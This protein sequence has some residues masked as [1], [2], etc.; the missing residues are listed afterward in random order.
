MEDGSVWMNPEIAARGRYP[1]ASIQSIRAIE[2]NKILNQKILFRDG[3]DLRIDPE[4]T[5]VLVDDGIATGATVIASIRMLKDAGCKRIVVAVPVCSDDAADRIRNEGAE[6]F[7]LVETDHLRSVGLW[8]QD[9]TQVEDEAVVRILKGFK[10]PMPKLNPGNRVVHTIADLLQPLESDSDLDPLLQ[11]IQAKHIAMLGEASHGTSEFYRIRD[12]IS[13]KLLKDS[14]FS[15]VAVEGDWPDLYRLNRYAK[16]GKGKS[17]KQV[18]QSFRRW[19]TWMWSNG[20]FESFVEFMRSEPKVSECGIYGLDVYSLFESMDSALEYVQSVNPFLAKAMRARYSCFEPYE[21][22]EYAYSRSLQRIPEGCSV[23]VLQNLEALLQMRMEKGQD[24][25]GRFS[26]EQNARIAVNAEN[27]YRALLGGDEHS[28]NVRDSHMLDTLDLLLDRYSRKKGTASKGIVW[29]HNTHVGDY[30]A[31]DMEREGYVNLGGLARKTYGRDAVSL[32]GFGTHSGKVM[33]SHAWGG[34]EQ[35]MVTPP[36]PEGTYEAFFHE[37]L[38][39]RK[40]KQGFVILGAR[41]REGV[42]AE[43]H[44]HRAIGVVYHSKQE[45]RGNYVPTSLA[46]RYDAF[47]FVDQTSALNS[48]HAVHEHG[49]FPETWPQG[50]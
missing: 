12:R 45:N 23:Q 49:K 9:F 21:R 5:V 25:E 44:G 42:L 8:Y 2:W 20:E 7:A 26:A 15:F 18:M 34:K 22:D 50:M 4:E 33:A 47:V 41:E 19:P 11:Q 35:I 10:V 1:D 14:E 31:T 24:D 3:R 32:V 48:F 16:L 37:A 46:N 6:V 27:Y 43:I 28:W 40:L 29:A 38:K 36:A 30:R 39:L 17:A 13:R